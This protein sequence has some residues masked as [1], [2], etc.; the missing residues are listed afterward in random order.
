MS[1]WR[2]SMT[3]P[4][5][6]ESRC[7]DCLLYGAIQGLADAVVLVDLEGRVFSLN[8]R[9]H[10]IL[11]VGSRFV[12]GTLLAVSLR[13]AGLAAFWAAATREL[14]P[15][16][17]EMEL[18]ECSSWRVTGPLCLSATREPIG[19]ALI[20]RDVTREKRLQVELSSAVAKR[21][22]EMSAIGKVSEEVLVLTTRE[23]EVL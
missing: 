8:R 3:I 11:G 1:P 15:V 7:G 17:T 10:E 5:E 21:L 14:V 9:A 19:R 20:L 18:P 23:R 16:A 12:L 6:L 22:V 13:D 2:I 4:V